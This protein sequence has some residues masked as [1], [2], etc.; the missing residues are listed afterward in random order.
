MLA[1]WVGR[2]DQWHLD[3]GKPFRHIEF[4]LTARLCQPPAVIPAVHS[5]PAFQNDTDKPPPDR[6]Q[7]SNGWI[8][9]SQRKRTNEECR[10]SDQNL[11]S[12]R[13]PS[14]GN[15]TSS[16]PGVM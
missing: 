1:H 3:L 6:R 14:I 9:S 8:M 11:K 12:Q 7:R 16:D 5:F 13:E 15:G 2:C 4:D 10:V